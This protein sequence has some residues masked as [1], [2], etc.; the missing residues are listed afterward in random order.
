MGINM[1]EAVHFLNKEIKCVNLKSWIITITLLSIMI[2]VAS[3]GQLGLLEQNLGLD[4][5][6]IINIV[7]ALNTQIEHREKLTELLF[8]VGLS[9]SLI[10]YVIYLGI[11][12]L[13]AGFQKG[14]SN[15]TLYQ[16]ILAPITIRDI[17][18]GSSFFYYIKALLSSV[19]SFII[20]AAFY[21]AIGF[22]L[23]FSL[24]FLMIYFLINIIAI[25]FIYVICTLVWLT[26]GNKIMVTTMR[27]FILAAIMLVIPASAGNAIPLSMVASDA[28]LIVTILIGSG[29]FILLS[30][31]LIKKINKE[32]LMTSI[33]KE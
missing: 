25:S 27:I 2:L 13:V 8:T 3:I 7:S 22:R 33:I 10:I 9:I 4:E 26:N 11:P 6:G 1:R 30:E 16:L 17:I 19:V 21:A 18:I 15:K 31:L 24:S 29:L 5:D 28:R 14:K 12:G 20:I 23:Y 32:K